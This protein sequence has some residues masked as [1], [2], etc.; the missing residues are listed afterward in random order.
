MFKL[1]ASSN[2]EMAKLEREDSQ[3]SNNFLIVLILATIMFSVIG[4]WI[5]L[6]KLS[7]L[8][9][10][11]PAPGIGLVNVTIN[12]SVS[13]SLNPQS[14]NFTGLN[15]GGSD[16]TIDLNP[17]PFNITNDGSVLINIT[18]KIGASLFTGTGSGQNT[19][20]FQACCGN[21]TSDGLCAQNKLNSPTDNRSTLCSDSTT[22]LNLS[23]T[24]IKYIAFQ[25]FADNND[26]RLL[27][28]NVTAPPDEPTGQKDATLT[29]TA[30]Q[31]T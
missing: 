4:T 18:V 26:T 19:S 12:S 5:S 29:F 17:P 7:P 6:T 3:V 16:N 11:V 30:S 25:D 22:F 14:V 2:K 20:T 21:H 10:L 27:H 1:K 15:P 9:G 8:T 23:T 24:A 13:F 28:L 31:A